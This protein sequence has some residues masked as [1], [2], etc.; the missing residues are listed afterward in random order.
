MTH[1]ASG[2]LKEDEQSKPEY[3]VFDRFISHLGRC[4]PPAGGQVSQLTGLGGQDTVEAKPA[5]ESNPWRRR[6]PVPHGTPPPSPRSLP[7]QSSQYKCILEAAAVHTPQSPA[8][9]PPPPHSHIR[10]VS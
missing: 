9:S 7:L 10:C 5:L 6:L 4:P 8:F 2:L 1:M 3:L